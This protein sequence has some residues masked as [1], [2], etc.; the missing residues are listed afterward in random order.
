MVALFLTESA[1]LGFIGGTLGVAIGM[2]ASRFVNEYVGVLLQN[3]GLTL[4]NIAIVPPWLAGGTIMVT[5]I[6]GII[7]GVYP[8]YRAARQDPVRALTE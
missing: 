8:A 4:T 5:T 7:A 1:L 3:Q 2:F 6:F